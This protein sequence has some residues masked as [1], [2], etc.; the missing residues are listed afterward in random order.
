M[1]SSDD[2]SLE[3][4]ANEEKKNG[5]SANQF[6]THIDLYVL[7]CPLYILT[8]SCAIVVGGRNDFRDSSELPVGDRTAPAVTAVGPSSSASDIEHGLLHQR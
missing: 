8:L 7:K 6:T 1:H 3:G 2:P 4:G 5:R